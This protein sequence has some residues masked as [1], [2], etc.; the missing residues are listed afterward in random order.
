MKV[1]R[2]NMD[3]SWWI[4]INNTKLLIDPWL[5]GKEVDFF[6]WFNTQW[7]KHTPIEYKDLPKFDYVLIT[8]KYPDHFHKETLLKLNPSKFIVPQS[9]EEKIRKLFP[10]AEIIS[11]GH[12]NKEF[13]IGDVTCKWFPTSRKI[14]PIYDA[15]LLSDDVESVFIATHGYTFSNTTQQ[16]SKPVTLLI[17]P[18]NFYKLP[19]FL[20]GTVSPG[21]KGLQYLND[22]LQPSYIAATHDEDK[23]AEG[24]VSK[25]AS[26]IR[27]GKEELKQHPNLSAKYLEL[28]HYSPI[29]L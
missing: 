19:F 9:I 20:G 23:H 18:F 1:Q 12:H 15:L 11:F 8:Q 6:S 27:I 26:I 13:E 22:V 28:D 21:I 14:D 2:L 10:K 25:L 5:H 17:S 4:E 29:E 24:I 3:N 16:P 7:H